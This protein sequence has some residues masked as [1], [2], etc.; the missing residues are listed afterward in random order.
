MRTSDAGFA[1]YTPTTSL[2]P[3]LVS[4]TLRLECPK[5]GKGTFEARPRSGDLTLDCERKSCGCS[6]WA[7]VV[8]PGAMGEYLR[9]LFSPPIAAA[10]LRRLLPEYARAA[11]ELLWRAPVAP[12]SARAYIQ[13]RIDGTTKHRSLHL[14]NDGMAAVLGL[15]A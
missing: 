14:D 5:C 7:I 8:P 13:V 11:E 1:P 2:R 12:P 3:A 4:L 6:W 9:T 15:V 10:I